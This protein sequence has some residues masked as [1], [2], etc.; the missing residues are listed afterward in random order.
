MHAVFIAATVVRL[1]GMPVHVI[2]WGTIHPNERTA[3]IQSV[4]TNPQAAFL[5]TV[6]AETGKHP[7][8]FRVVPDDGEGAAEIFRLA[9]RRR[10]VAGREQIIFMAVGR[11]GHGAGNDF[12]SSA[13]DDSEQQQSEADKDEGGFQV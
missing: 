4:Q 10:P 7:F 8:L 2:H 9:F 11:I 1:A 6:V 3:G 12:R 5:V 13:R